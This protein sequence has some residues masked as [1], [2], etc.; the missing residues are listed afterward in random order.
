MKSVAVICYSRAELA[1][2]CIK[3]VI[4]AEKITEIYKILIFQK[5]NQDVQEV[6]NTHRSKFDLVVEVAR[7]GNSTQNINANRY[8]AYSIAFDNL[9]SDYL[10]VFED[11]V[12]ISRDAIFF[13]DAIF[14][15]YKRDKKFRAFNFGSGIEFSEGLVHSYSKVR[16]ALQGPASLIPRRTWDHF[17]KKKLASKSKWEIFDG[18]FE[19]YIQSGFV[20]MPNNSRYID[21]GYE[22]THAKT[23]D[24]SNYFTKLEK[25]WVGA[26]MIPLIVPSKKNM[27]LL[28]R[29]DCKIYKSRY[30]F[31]FAVRNYFVF[32]RDK[33]A[34]GM[35]LF[36]FRKIKSK[37]DQQF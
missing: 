11:D 20:V 1:D 36:I 37:F 16:Y 23:T 35:F 6:V 25:S 32:R 28:W 13:A 2:N 8:L 22:G 9:F 14:N 24:N 18:T 29:K 33:F 12:Q 30:N 5:G 27:D 31:Y 19:T 4:N 15:E 7:E 26:H 21:F 34:I 17:D 3:S 10:M